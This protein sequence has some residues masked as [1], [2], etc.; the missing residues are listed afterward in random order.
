MTATTS[1]QRNSSRLAVRP[2]RPPRAESATTA[3]HAGLQV[4]RLGAADLPA[5]EQHL[6]GLSA[7][8]RRARFLVDVPDAV[9]AAYARGLDPAVAILVGAFNRDGRM[10]ALAEA[11]PADPPH[12][13]EVAVSID[14]P[15]RCCKLGQRLVVRALALA[16]DRGAQ[17]AEFIFAPQNRALA[18]LVLALG[19][20]IDAPG[21]AAIARIVDQM[22]A[23]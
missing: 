11:H 10:V 5:V 16:S 19:G 2:D 4:R 7:Q 3:R 6:L 17:S 9:I 18:G 14:A 1:Q 12:I 21:H 13:V 20:R 23:A 22:K 15:L 8:D